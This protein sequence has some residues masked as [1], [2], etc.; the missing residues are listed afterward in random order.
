M[1]KPFPLQTLLEL[2]RAH[3][4]TAAAQLGVLN[5]HER[6]MV[7][8]LRTLI[9]YRREYTDNLARMARTGIGS[10]DWRNYREF[11]DKIDAAISQQRATVAVSKHEVQV[12]LQNWHSEQRK[13]KSF[14]T[15]SVRHH[16]AEIR[17]ESVQEQKEQDEFALKGFLGRSVAMG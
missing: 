2:A 13:L 12:G 7:E 3:S 10:V 8:R 9:E 1:S 5:R 14:D 4:D 6:E 11:I 16:S 15:L 17:R